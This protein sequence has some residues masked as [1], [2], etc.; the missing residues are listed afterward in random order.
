MYTRNIGIQINRKEL[1]ETFMMISNRKR[2]LCYVGLNKTYVSALTLIVRG[3]M[4]WCL[5]SIP[6]L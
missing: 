5:K 4:F 6:T 2:N 3:S 1:S